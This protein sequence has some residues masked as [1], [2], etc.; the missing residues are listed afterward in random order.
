VETGPSR[1]I[2]IERQAA[3]R[4]AL[5][6][7]FGRSAAASIKPASSGEAYLALAIG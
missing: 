5:L 2:A 3:G 6:F 4:S 1:K 7:T